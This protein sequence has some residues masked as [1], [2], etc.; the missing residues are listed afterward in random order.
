ML[1]RKPMVVAII[2]LMSVAGN[3]WAAGDAER[4]QDVIFDCIECHGQDGMGDFET[5]EIAGLKE[6]Y[7][8]KQLRAFYSRKRDSLD[9]MMH[10]YTEE[11][12]DQ[13]LQ[14]LAAYWATVKPTKAS[15]D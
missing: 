7:I 10:V 6:D 4:G 13:D 12:T 14:D 2:V 15:S 5:P 9:D 11:R 8:L 3:A 1:I